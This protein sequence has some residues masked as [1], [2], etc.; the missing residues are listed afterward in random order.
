MNEEVIHGAF[1]RQKRSLLL[2]S[3]AV[4]EIQELA[5]T[6]AGLSLGGS[7]SEGTCAT[8]F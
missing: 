7:M 4:A 8:H 5:T 6:G 1:S 2:T 3:L